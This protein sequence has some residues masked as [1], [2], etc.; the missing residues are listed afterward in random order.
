MM[1][2]MTQTAWAQRQTGEDRHEI[3]VTL[4]QQNRQITCLAGTSQAYEQALAE[5]LVAQRDPD[6]DAE[7]IVGRLDQIRIQLAQ[8]RQV[9]LGTDLAPPTATVTAPRPTT[10][11]TTVG[12]FTTVPTTR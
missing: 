2:F 6:S 12:A 10:T 4:D 8:N 7:F 3:L 5:L 9:C 11:R 1:I